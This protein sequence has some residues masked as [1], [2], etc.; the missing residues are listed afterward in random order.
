MEAW[1]QDHEQTKA[2]GASQ[3]LKDGA[4]LDGGKTMLPACWNTSQTK[5]VYEIKPMTQN[6]K[7]KKKGGAENRSTAKIAKG[8]SGC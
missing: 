2:G 7:T 4:G 8:E 3:K 1:Q 6:G 5:Q